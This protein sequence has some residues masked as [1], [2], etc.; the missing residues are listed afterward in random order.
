MKTTHSFA[1]P[2]DPEIVFST[3]VKRLGQVA[4]G[5]SS[6]GEKAGTQEGES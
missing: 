6:D 2:A 4:L 1:L 3:P 5:E